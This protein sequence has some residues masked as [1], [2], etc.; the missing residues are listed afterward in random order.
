MT[1]LGT[2]AFD[3][4]TTGFAVDDQLTVIG[5]DTDVG[6]RSVLNTGGQ[7]CP[8]DLEAQVNKELN[9]SASVSVQESEQ[10]LLG[11]MRSFVESTL[12]HR[13]VKLVAFD[14]L[15]RVNAEES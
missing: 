11:E 12:A 4:E 1:G 13:D 15:L 10:T 2:V 14:I 3:I 7:P 8:S 5:F 9:P 6:S